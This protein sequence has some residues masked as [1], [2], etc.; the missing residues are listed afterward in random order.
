[1]IK[2]RV[3]CFL[4]LLFLS[5]L[6]CAT[7]PS[8]QHIKKESI[9]QIP[10]LPLGV[11]SWR[12]IYAHAFPP[13]VRDFVFPFYWE[14]GFLE[15]LTLVWAPLPFEMRYLFYQN[16]EMWLSG[17]TSLLGSI[18]TRDINFYWRPDLG[19]VLRKK[20]TPWLAFES[21]LFLQ[22]E[23]K[24][25]REDALARTYVARQGAL[26]QPFP[27]LLLSASLLAL[28]EKGETIARYLGAVPKEN[29]G[30][31]ASEKSRW[32]F[33]LSTDVILQLSPQWQI[34]FNLTFYHF[35]YGGEKV[36]APLYVSLVYF[37]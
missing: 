15:K 36:S 20:V 13:E 35:G 4:S 31:Q 28:N 26:F 29:Q 9:D 10:I 30:S 5:S 23:V 11:S 1:M 33:P 2:N 12:L 17:H 18:Y 27:F 25:S 21:E 37:W 22:L 8:L 14:H 24:R 19:F 16:E 32:R 6:S 7:S 34:L 3:L